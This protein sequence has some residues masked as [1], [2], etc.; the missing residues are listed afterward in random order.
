MKV[1]ELTTEQADSLRNQ[2]LCTQSGDK[3]NPIEDANGVFIIT[4]KER[5]KCTIR[6]FDWLNNLDEIDYIAKEYEPL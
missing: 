1:L 5:E 3:F 6:E 2:V 4:L